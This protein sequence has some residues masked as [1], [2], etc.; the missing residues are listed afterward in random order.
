M[1][2]SGSRCFDFVPFGFLVFDSINFA[3]QELH[4][5]HYRIHVHIGVREAHACLHRRLSFA[6]M[7]EVADH[8]V[9]RWLVSFRQVIH[10][11]VVVTITLDTMRPPSLLLSLNNKKYNQ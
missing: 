11:V 10:Y 7:C 9:G 2:T 3:A 1:Q 4:D 6:V 5:R 8:L